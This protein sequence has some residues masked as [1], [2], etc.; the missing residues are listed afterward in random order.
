MLINTEK[1]ASEIVH[2]YLREAVALRPSRADLSV[3]SGSSATTSDPTEP[4][5]V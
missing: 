3:E 1:R 4:D 2:I 5:G